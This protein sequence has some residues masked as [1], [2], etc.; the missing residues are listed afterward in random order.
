MTA[1]AV[2]FFPIMCTQHSL[3]AKIIISMLGREPPSSQLFRDNIS[4][5]SSNPR[6]SVGLLAMSW[7]FFTS[8]KRH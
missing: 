8:A 7:M 6:N 3:L 1:A 5:M 2:F 4:E